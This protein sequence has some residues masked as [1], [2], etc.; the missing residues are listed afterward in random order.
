MTDEK[1]VHD[2]FLAVH[3]PPEVAQK[4]R[5]RIERLRA[6]EANTSKP[7]LVVTQTKRPPRHRSRLIALLQHV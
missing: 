6:E 5:E 1:H 7:H 4:T 3:V 2:A